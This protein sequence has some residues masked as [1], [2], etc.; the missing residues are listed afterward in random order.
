MDHVPGR[1]IR[2]CLTL[3]ALCGL[4]TALGP[5]QTLATGTTALSAELA[6]ATHP[7]DPAAT[8]AAK[9]CRRGYTRVRGRCRRKLPT[10]AQSKR[11]FRNALTGS[12]FDRAY[13]S[14]NYAS[15][16]TERY[17]FCNGTYS[18]YAEHFTDYSASTTSD[19]GTWRVLKARVNRARTAGE[20]RVEYHSTDSESPDTVIV[21][22]VGENQAFIEDLEYHRTANSASC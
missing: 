3:V 12:R 14:S 21:T 18:Y 7:S 16:G 8:A 19:Q 10:P 2:L 1:R 5:S 20:A 11:L 17:D 13:S 22:I 6:A 9:R 15:S 4:A